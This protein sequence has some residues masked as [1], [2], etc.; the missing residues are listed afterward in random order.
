M[1][2]YLFQK[3]GQ[4]KF[5][6]IFLP[7]SVV[8]LIQFSSESIAFQKNLVVSPVDKTLELFTFLRKWSSL[9]VETN[10]R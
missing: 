1:E 6:Y 4:L 8:L 10:K 5:R 3:N 9:M 7:T 2:S